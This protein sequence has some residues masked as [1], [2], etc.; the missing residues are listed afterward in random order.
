MF[1]SLPVL[2]TTR[3]PQ[4]AG[5]S[6]NRGTVI[7]IDARDL[8]Q[9]I[10]SLFE[11]NGKADFG[12][13]FDWYYRSNGQEMPTSW[14]LRDA[15]GRV[16][17]LCSVTIRAMR[18]G[19]IPVRAGVAGNLLVDRNRGAYLAAFSLVN[20]IKSLVHDHEIDVL[21]G[22]PN[23]L[24]Q[25]VFS[26]LG[27]SVIA[28]WTTYVQVVKSR[29][30]LRFHFGAS[31]ALASPLVDWAAALKRGLCGWQG[32]NNSGFRVIQLAEHEVSQ[33]RCDEWPFPA[34]RFRLIADGEYLKWRF[35]R[36]PSHEFHLVGIVSSLGKICAYLVVRSAGGRIWI[37]DCA[38]DHKQLTEVETMQ[39]FCK[40]ARARN[41]TVWIPVLSSTTFSRQLPKSGLIKISSRRGGYPDFP[42]VGYWRT[43]HPLAH[44]FG[45]PS[46]WELLSGFNDV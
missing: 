5:S 41:S 42:L 29:D 37:A 33:I 45:Q 11:A 26:R 8:R 7:R 24:A 17:G 18:F 43:D 4:R 40:D 16:L 36:A 13:R 20:A 19:N 39:C 6:K 1:T 34:D 21:L 10:I 25:P 2:A 30:L 46:S 14:V 22:I 15:R 28:R 3:S 12:K 38:A 32:T 9:E 23:E 44:A 35:A 27:F 31:G